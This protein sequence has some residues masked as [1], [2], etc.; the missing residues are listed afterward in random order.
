VKK[1]KIHI[2][3]QKKWKKLIRKLTFQKNKMKKK[4]YKYLKCAMKEKAPNFQPTHL[5]RESKKEIL[6]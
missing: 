5:Q 4:I 1:V 2:S 3:I 6:V